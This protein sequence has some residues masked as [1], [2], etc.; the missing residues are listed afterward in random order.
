MKNPIICNPTNSTI[1]NETHFNEDRNSVTCSED[2]GI[3]SSSSDDIPMA[4]HLKYSVSS[5]SSSTLL[6]GHYNMNT[7]TASESKLQIT[8]ISTINKELGFVNQTIRPNSAS[9]DISNISETEGSEVVSPMSLPG[10]KPP[11][12]DRGV[13]K[14]YTTLFIRLF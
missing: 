8:G 5:P 9:S 4:T 10:I 6:G 2:S 1:T 7:R 14:T 13:R 11:S 12:L 3:L